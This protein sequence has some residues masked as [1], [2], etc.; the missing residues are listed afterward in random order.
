MFDL[1]HNYWYSIYSSEKEVVPVSFG[2]QRKKE[3]WRRD[4]NVFRPHSA[5]NIPHT[6]RIYPKI[7]P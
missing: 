6:G 1:N 7:G 5:L 4:Y 2:R 3:R